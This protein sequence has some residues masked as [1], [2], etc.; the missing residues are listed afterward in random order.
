MFCRNVMIYF[1]EE[2]KEKVL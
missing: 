1:T 2:Q